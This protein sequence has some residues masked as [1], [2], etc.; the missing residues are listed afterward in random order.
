M[1]DEGRWAK[2]KGLITTRYTNIKKT[3]NYYDFEVLI[4]LR[5]LLSMKKEEP[6]DR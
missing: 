3:Q 4:T 6:L 1:N 2:R 5:D